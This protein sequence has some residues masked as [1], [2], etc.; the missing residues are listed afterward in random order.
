MNLAIG[1]QGS[2]HVTATTAALAA[3]IAIGSTAQALAADTACDRLSQCAG[4]REGHRIVPAAGW[5][6][7]L[8]G[9]RNDGRD[10]PPPLWCDRDRSVLS[11]LGGLVGGGCDRRGRHHA[12]AVRDSWQ[13]A[14]GLAVK[15]H[16]TCLAAHRIARRQRCVVPAGEP[17]GAGSP[18]RR[19]SP[20][21][22]D[23]GDQPT[24]RRQ[25][26]PASSARHRTFLCDFRHGRP[27]QVSPVCTDRVAGFSRD[28]R[29]Q[30]EPARARCRACVV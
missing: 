26:L 7:E 25:W 16:G 8:P 30:L 17:L 4:S 28:C 5:A 22:R 24:N 23:R 10:K 12:A 20:A 2:R 11:K 18:A 3:T 1:Y 15:A 29:T 27:A 21:R 9:Q 14:P 19:V 6:V 13:A